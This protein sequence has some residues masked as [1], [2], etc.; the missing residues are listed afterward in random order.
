M[1]NQTL[2]C[3]RCNRIFLRTHDLK[4]HYL[5]K[6]RCFM[7][8]Q[9]SPEETPPGWTPELESWFQNRW[10]NMESTFW[11]RVESLLDRFQQQYFQ[12]HTK[13]NLPPF[14]SNRNGFG[15]ETIVHLTDTDKNEILQS[16]GLPLILRK[17]HFSPNEPRNA[18]VYCSNWRSKVIYVWETDHEWHRVSFEDWWSSWI[19]QVDIWIQ[20]WTTDSMHPLVQL[21]YDIK[22]NPT[23]I[24]I[25]KL[26]NSVLHEL[27]FQKASYFT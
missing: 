20:Q 5:R 10:S 19:D 6:N 3:I 26:Q 21:I 24:S 15:E 22:H 25:R 2:R 23:E 18:N 9:M 12:I 1:E 27:C 13:I 8:N 7:W 16:K 17:V 11:T 14:L 4:R